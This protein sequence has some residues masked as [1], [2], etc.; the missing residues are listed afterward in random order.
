MIEKKKLK[1]LNRFTITNKID[2]YNK[3][4]EKKEK[5]EKWKK[6]QKKPQNKSK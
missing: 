1:S 2:N 5:N 6:I 4:K 3:R